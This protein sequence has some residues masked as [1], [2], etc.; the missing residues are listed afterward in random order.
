MDPPKVKETKEKLLLMGK[1]GSGKSSMRKIIFSNFVAK[2]VRRLGA[3][4]GYEE[5]K[6]KFLGNMVLNLFDCGG[7]SS[8]IE[9][10]LRDDRATVFSSVSVLIYVFDVESREPE[11]DL[12]TYARIISVLATMS[13]RTRIFCLVHKMDLVHADYREHLFQTR[14]EAIID[15]SGFFKDSVR[16]FGTTIWNQSLYR[17]WGGIVNCLIPNVGVIRAYLEHLAE[18]VEAEEVILF[19]RSTFLS[20]LKVV[21]ELGERNPRGERDEWV[22]NIMKT[23]KH[24]LA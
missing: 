3:T 13:P 21:N 24:A 5:T 17:A 20:V 12:V 1:S 18:V 9:T 15:R 2:D 23:Y 16:C 19:E 14:Q 11:V 10:Y 6:V 4:I 7:Q 8:F 22:S